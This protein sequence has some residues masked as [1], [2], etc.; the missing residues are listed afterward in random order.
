MTLYSK[1]TRCLPLTLGSLAILATLFAS[2]EAVAQSDKPPADATY[3]HNWTDRDGLSH[4]TLCNLQDFKLE[5]MAPPADPLWLNSQ[6][7]GDT[8]VLT[9]IKPVGWKGNW[10]SDK[11][12][13]WVVTLAGK[14]FVEAMDDTRVELDPGDVVLIENMQAQRDVEGEEGHRSGNI[15]N[16]VVK[17]LIVQLQ[18]TPA[19]DQPCRFK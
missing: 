4:L 5:S 2:L 16:E 19:V 14:W 17:L 6:K 18:E 10:H 8:R 15:G 3:W 13:L 11:E 12:V 9:I 1:W 7:S